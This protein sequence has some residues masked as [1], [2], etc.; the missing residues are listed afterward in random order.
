MVTLIMLILA[1][2]VIL[3]FGLMT[4]CP[5]YGLWLYKG[6]IFGIMIIFLFVALFFWL[7]G[8]A[9]A[10]ALNINLHPWKNYLLYRVFAAVACV[11]V[12]LAISQLPLLFVKCYAKKIKKQ[13]YIEVQRVSF[14]QGL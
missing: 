4:K 14:I 8:N 11:M 5:K 13:N 12:F 2:A 3:S 10:S 6:A 1:F 7:G 9:D